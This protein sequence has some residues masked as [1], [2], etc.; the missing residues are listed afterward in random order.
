MTIGGVD[1]DLFDGEIRYHDVIRKHY[2]TMKLDDVLVGDRSLGLC[3]DG[4]RIV[5]DTGTSMITGPS[6]DVGKLLGEI[7]V[8]KDFSNLEDLPNI[9]FVLDGTHY[10]LSPNDYLM[11]VDPVT[12]DGTPYTH[13]KGHPVAGVITPLDV[14]KPEG[15]T[16]ILGN[17]FLSK[18]YTVFDRDHDRVGFAKAKK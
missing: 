3:E 10:P 5:V 8:K 6:K 16:W 18:Y 9:T 12:G 15:P 17:I 7:K 2:W 13:T 4:C 11:S 14:P 1:E